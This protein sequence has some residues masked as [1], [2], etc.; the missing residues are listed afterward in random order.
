MNAIKPIYSIRAYN[1]EDGSFHAYVEVE[2]RS[3][4]KTLRIAI[5]HAKDFTKRFPEY[6][7]EVEDDC[8]K[9]ATVV[10]GFSYSKEQGVRLY[11]QTGSFVFPG[12]QGRALL[13]ALGVS[14]TCHSLFLGES[15]ANIAA[16]L[17]RV[18]AA[19]E[20]HDA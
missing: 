20:P 12:E 6:I 9:R 11:T 3:E 13:E 17:H 5:K 14:P 16:L 15:I 2:G 4:W 8:G 7:T 18:N 19:E 10:N 1:R